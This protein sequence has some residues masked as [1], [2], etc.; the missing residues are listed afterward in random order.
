MCKFKGTAV[1]AP[2]LPPALDATLLIYILTL[3]S[4][5]ASL[6]LLLPLP[7]FEPTNVKAKDAKGDPEA[8]PFPNFLWYTL[9]LLKLVKSVAWVGKYPLKLVVTVLLLK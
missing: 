3:W 7:Q 1:L 6:I 9:G 2:K 4:F 5:K 8:G